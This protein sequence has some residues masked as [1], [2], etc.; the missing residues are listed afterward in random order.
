MHGVVHEVEVEEGGDGAARRYV[1]HLDGHGVMLSGRLDGNTLDARVDAHR[2]SVTVVEHDGVFSLFAAGDMSEFALQP[3]D[4]GEDIEHA[5]ANAF[6]APMN[7]SVVAVLVD[8]GQAVAKGDT[9]LIMEA[10]KMEH[11][12]RA[13]AAGCVR[14]FFFAPGDLVDGGAELLAFEIASASA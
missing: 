6:V 8:A 11:A 5:G 10:M 2:G 9:L 13:P 1:L 4:Q 14:E 12:I 7:G 3:A